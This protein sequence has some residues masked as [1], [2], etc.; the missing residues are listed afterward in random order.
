MPPTATGRR[1]KVWPTKA[2][3]AHVTYRSTYCECC[4]FS[5]QGPQWGWDRASS[6]G[7]AKVFACDVC[8]EWA[9][10]LDSTELFK[11]LPG[12]PQ[13]TGPIG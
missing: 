11:A 3:P 1:G 7:H 5:Y 9:L 13:P 6:A 12:A 4:G 10:I 8:D 2:P